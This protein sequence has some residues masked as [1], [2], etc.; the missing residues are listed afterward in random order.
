VPHVID[1]LFLASGL[2]L[3][4]TIAQY[5]FLTGWLTAK[6]SGL[7]AYILLGMTAMSGR[8]SRRARAIAFFTALLSYAWIL[9]VAMLKSPWG[10]LG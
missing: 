10:F 9:S 5:P 7:L 4:W 1:T 6:V 2:T 3:A 8:I